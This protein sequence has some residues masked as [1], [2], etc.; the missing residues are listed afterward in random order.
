[1]SAIKN[2]TK[3]FSEMDGHF[4]EVLTGA[5]VA[6]VLRILGA[7]AAFALN[8]IIGRLLGAEGAGLYF[9]AL[10]VALIGSILAQLGLASTLLRFIAAGAAK[11]D[12]GQIKGVF[13][14]GVKLSAAAS[15]GIAIIIAATAPW[16]AEY[17]FGK[18]ALTTP[19]RYM[20]LAVI[21]FSMMTLLAESLKGL[22]QIGRSML[23]TGVIYPVVALVLIWPL[24]TLAGPAGASLAYVI[25]TGVA[26]LIGAFW[27]QA[28]TRNHGPAQPIPAPELW[29]SARPLLVMN[30]IL[31]GIIPLAPLFLVG[32]W[33]SAEDAGIYGAAA[34]L[35]LLASFFL[36]AVNS[37]IA[38]KFAELYTKGD[39]ATLARVTRRFAVGITLATSPLFLVL[40]FAGDW[41][42]SLFG[43]DFTRGGS[44]LAILAV[45]QLVNSMFGSSVFL[46]MM[47]GYEKDIRTSSLIAVAVLALLLV[48]LVPLYGLI[49]AAISASAAY[50][51]LTLW[52]AFM[53]GKRL[54][55][56]LLPFTAWKT[57][58]Q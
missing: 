26:A 12:W 9:L 32:V 39:M 10:S 14:Q 21:T 38:P 56:Q 16:S 40:F 34:R 53:V 24:A 2:I 52:S 33:S 41:V 23:V 1:M 8:V 3:R 19:L 48:T 43:P 20:S 15:L 47:S 29:Q 50:S 35:A 30:L 18:P 54:N 13:F 45:G 7:A 25:G 11:N 5:S 22:K 17:I 4:R 44:T 46:L 58:N 42:M 49:G 51:I 36:A 28:E 31:R 57:P 27:W 55:I 37:A 6:F